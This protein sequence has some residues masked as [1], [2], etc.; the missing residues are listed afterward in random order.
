ME[1]FTFAR[2]DCE[3]H[4]IQSLSDRAPAYQ[5]PYFSSHTL[6]NRCSCVCVPASGRRP[7]SC[8]DPSHRSPGRW[9]NGVSAAANF[10]CWK[11]A[12]LSCERSRASSRRDRGW[13]WRL[14]YDF[15]RVARNLLAS[16]LRHYV[17]HDLL[18]SFRWKMATYEL[19]SGVVLVRVYFCGTQSQT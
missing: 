8:R 11:G 6:L 4:S 2:S 18:C 17:T 15:N 19:K 12:V 16:R 13:I 9:P 1:L 5:I 10:R 3:L 14:V 7:R